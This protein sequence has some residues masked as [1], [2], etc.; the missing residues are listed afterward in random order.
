[1]LED[2]SVYTGDFFGD[3]SD[4]VGEV[5]FNTGMT[6]Y[7]EL[8]S[9]PSYH[10]QIVVMTYPLIGNYGVNDSD[11]ESDG[12]QVRGFIVRENIEKPCNWMMQDTIGHHLKNAG[13]PAL[14]GVDTRAIT[15]KLREYGTMRG[16]ITDNPGSAALQ[17]VKEYSIIDPVR[18]VTCAEPYRIRG[19]GYKVAVLDM[20]IKHGIFDS[21]KRRGCDMTVYPSFTTAEEILKGDPDGIFLSNGPGDP[22]DNTGIIEQ[23]RELINAKPVFGI[24]LGF[25]LIGLAVGGDT[26]KLRYGHRGCNHP[27]KD[28]RQ[29]RTYITSQNH[30][31]AVTPASLPDTVEIT[32]L[33]WNDQTLEGM[34]LTDKPTFG[35]QFHPE[36]RPGP[37]DTAY[38]FDD[39]IALMG[40]SRKGVA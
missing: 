14:A 29:G 28:I 35:V 7:Q 19:D 4:V 13:I 12:V 5:V 18:E 3:A 8:L 11:N 20:G 30:G 22:K 15:R 39:F 16:I 23:I 33:N 2:G 40:A 9:D 36:G 38:L 37:Q 6:G 21:L 24:C 17:K 10:G 1:M 25:Q 31:Y 26:Q 27:V 34:R 32:H